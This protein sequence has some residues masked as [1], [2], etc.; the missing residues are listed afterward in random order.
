MEIRS[1]DGISEA[2]RSFYALDALVIKPE[3]RGLINTTL[4]VFSG[5]TRYVATLFNFKTPVQVREIA[6]IM[7][8]LEGL[9]I[10]KP[11]HG[12]DGYVHDIAG[13]SI[14]VCPFIEGYHAVG[15]DHTRKT[16]IGDVTHR[17]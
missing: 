14:I 16:P 1:Y 13:K 5:E 8:S 9:P 3:T 10:A 6:E 7:L 17:N 12:R 11:I 2:M 4:H 15:E